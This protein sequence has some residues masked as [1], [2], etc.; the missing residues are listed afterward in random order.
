VLAIVTLAA[1]VG[2]LSTPLSAS[3]G[4]APATAAQVAKLVAASPNIKTINA[5][6]AAELPNAAND[7]PWVQYGVLGINGCDATTRC[8]YGDTKAKKAIV[9]FGDSHASMWL[10]A[11][12]PWATAHHERLIL[13]WAPGCPPAALPTA[14]AWQGE[15][16]GLS[17]AACTTWR[18]AAVAYVVSL[19]PGAI[20]LAERTAEIESEPSGLRFTSS[21]WRAALVT[22]IKQLSA[23]KAKIAVIEDIPLHKYNA[24]A[25]LSQNP[26]AVQDCSTPFPS[27]DY[28]GQQ[29]AEGNAAKATKSALI[30]TIGWFCTKNHETCS[31]V[32]GNFI[33]YSDNGH[34]TASYANYLEGVMG[35][36]I[37]KVVG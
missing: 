11:I 5:T 32:I 33:A 30:G 34:V 36:A 12:A 22:T 18:K 24:P 13:V 10:S 14:W 7:Q 35:T 6:V 17:N 9:L 8:I 21:Q 31:D 27:L 3:A 20:L 15:A 26:D 16:G 23:A 25:C 1:F 19:H 37:A 28:P 4:G 2:A 29:V